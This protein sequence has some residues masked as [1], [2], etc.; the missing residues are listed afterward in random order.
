[1]AYQPKVV[2]EVCLWDNRES[3]TFD[4]P[5]S[6]RWRGGK[7]DLTHHFF[8]HHTRLGWVENTFLKNENYVIIY[9][10][11][12]CCQ[13]ERVSFFCWTHRKIFW[14]MIGTLVPLT[15]IVFFSTMEVNG[16]KQLFGSNRSSKYLPMCSAEERNSYMFV[17]IWEWV[18]DDRI[19]IF[20]RSI[21]STQ[22]SP[23][24]LNQS[25]STSE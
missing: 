11:W 22:P 17:T 3:V 2:N 16:T 21:P 23:S 24:H 18:N 15:S 19:F 1:M 4:A 14:R 7:D 5:Y 12:S 25:I 8:Y 20:G 13:L 6:S 10:R 9:S